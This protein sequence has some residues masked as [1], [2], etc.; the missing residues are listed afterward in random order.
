VAESEETLDE[1]WLRFELRRPG[2]DPVVE[3]PTPNRHS[4]TASPRRTAAVIAVV[5]AGNESPRHT[6][7]ESTLPLAEAMDLVQAASA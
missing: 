6:R 1:H 5:I 3:R 4:F 2:A 7:L